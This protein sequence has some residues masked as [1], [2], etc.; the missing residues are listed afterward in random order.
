MSNEARLRAPV[1][2][3]LTSVT[4]DE[5]N[6]LRAAGARSHKYWNT[7]PE[8]DKPIYKS[9]KTEVKSHY[10]SEQ[11]T[12][13]CYCSVE[14]Q[15][16]HS[17]FDAEHILDKSTHPQFMFELNNLAASCRPCNRAKSAK[18]VLADG[19]QCQTVSVE[20]TDYQIVHPHLDEWDHHL[21]FDELNRIR[22]KDKSLKGENTINICGINAL[23][24]ARLSNFFS[25]S[26]GNAEQHLRNFF[27]LKQPGKK[28]AMLGLLQDLA[29]RG[30]AK[31]RAIV[32]RL[33]EDV[34]MEQEA[35]QEVRVQRRGKRRLQV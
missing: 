29:N 20:S 13:C 15:N 16:D 14:I 12:R 26:R 18:V 33:E 9:F 30:E 19:V 24:A 3:Q 23:N 6:R 35:A 32:E 1:L 31:A 7:Q 11:G 2:P 21:M 4:E 22:P 10:R 25:A 27:N 17:T 8:E 28:Q 34:K 5:H